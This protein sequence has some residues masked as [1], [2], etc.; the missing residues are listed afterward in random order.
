MESNDELKEIDIKNCVTISM[1]QI[2]IE[3]FDFDDNILFNEKRYKNILVYKFDIKL[4]LLQNHYLSVSINQMYL[5]EFMTGLDII[6]PWKKYDAIYNKIRYFIGQKIDITYVIS[7]NYARVKTDSYD[8][9]PLEKTLTL[10]NVIIF[11]RSVFDKDQNRY[12]YNIFSG[13][14][15]I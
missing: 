3:G 8:S 5:L 7:H 14:M 15:F 12:Y 13:K 6:R 11:I 1:K 10:R 9:L 4:W 2:K